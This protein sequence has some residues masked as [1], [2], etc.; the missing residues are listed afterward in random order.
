MKTASIILAAMLAAPA[1][2]ET[3]IGLH[4]VSWHSGGNCMNN[5]N[6]GA[7]VQVENGTT[8][9]TYHNSCGRQTFYVGGEVLSHRF[10][11]V[12]GSV[13]AMAATGY[14]M[15]ITPGA[16]LTLKAPISK[17]DSVRLAG[18]HWDGV[19]VLHLTVERKF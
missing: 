15:P 14:F 2:A 8:F 1:F 6:P 4:T 18:N 12:E 9:G 17:T 11:P 16:F 7:Y 10:G 3:T 19:T 5:E 13:F